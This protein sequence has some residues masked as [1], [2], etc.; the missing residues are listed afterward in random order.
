MTSFPTGTSGRTSSV[1]SS[2]S[3]SSR[4][5]RAGD[6]DDVGVE[7][8]QRERELFLVLDGDRASEPEIEGTFI[9]ALEQVSLLFELTENQ[10]ERIRPGLVRA[11]ELVEPMDSL[12]QEHREG[13][14]LADADH[15]IESSDCHGFR[16]RFGCGFGKP[17]DVVREER[18]DRDAV[19]FRDGLNES[20]HARPSPASAPAG[21]PGSRPPDTAG[22]TRL[23]GPYYHT[24]PSGPAPPATPEA[25]ARA[26]VDT[27]QLTEG[28]SDADRMPH[29]FQL[30]EGRGV[31]GGISVT[32][33][34]HALHIVGSQPL[35]LR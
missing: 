2:S 29:G 10:H 16:A 31:P 8:L 15:V 32:V 26:G 22:G 4:G 14:G 7:A 13:D 25:R 33:S 12:S 35:E 5:I 18:H 21:E 23:S 9:Q 3:C 30:Q 24:V 11:L 1:R 6:R 28:S 20:T 19:T 27:R 34:H 17:V